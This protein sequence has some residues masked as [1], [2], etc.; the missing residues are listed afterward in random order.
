MKIGAMSD[1]HLEFGEYTGSF[2]TGD[3]LVVAGDLHVAAYIHSQNPEV[4]KQDIMGRSVRFFKRALEN[5]DHVITVMGNHEHYNGIFNYTPTILRAHFNADTGFKNLHLLEKEVIQIKGVNFFGATM[6]TDFN[7][8]NDKS[9][10]RAQGYM[11]DYEQIQVHDENHLHEYRQFEP[12]D[13]YQE[14]LAT[15]AD[16]HDVIAESRASNTKCVV[17]SHHAPSKRSIHPRY[18]F[19][20]HV[21][22]AYATDLEHVLQND[23]VPLWIHGHMHDSFDYRV[24][25]TN[26]I[27]NPRGYVGHKLNPHFNPELVVEI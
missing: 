12:E 7:S 4:L 21:N 25:N 8:N 15:I 26:V 24:H 6:W 13:A 27:C 10:K 3:V 18:Q 9:R 16:L 11:A 17:V 5:Y 2:G 19:D 22:G 14:H 1:I 20:Y 23:V